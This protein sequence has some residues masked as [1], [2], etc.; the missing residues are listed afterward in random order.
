MKRTVSVDVA[1]L[2]L[3]RRGGLGKVTIFIQKRGVD[4]ERRMMLFE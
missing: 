1:N 3:R 2:S 4:K